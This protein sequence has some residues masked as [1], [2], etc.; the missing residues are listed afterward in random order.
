MRSGASADFGRLFNTTRNGSRI[1]DSFL[2]NHRSTAAKILKIVTSAIAEGLLKI[3]ESTIPAAV[4][5][6]QRK[7]NP[8][9]IKTREKETMRR[10]CLR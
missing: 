1:S 8:V 6:S 9:R 2:L 4:V 5:A 3:K 10:C 7:R